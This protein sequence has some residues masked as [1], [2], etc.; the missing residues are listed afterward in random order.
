MYLDAFRARIESLRSG[1]CVLRITKKHAWGHTPGLV[2]IRFFDWST[3][4]KLRK[5]II[6][7]YE[8]YL[9]NEAKLTAK[10]K[11]IQESIVPFAMVAGSPALDP[12]E[13]PDSEVLGDTFALLFFD[14]ARQTETACPVLMA[15]TDSFKLKTIA[16]SLESLGVIC[17]GR[18]WAPDGIVVLDR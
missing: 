3:A 8:D 12:K 9:E 14:A 16:P 2:A 1:S 13:W 7:S 6:E 17:V 5:E 18:D 4:K 15:T 10:G 11:W